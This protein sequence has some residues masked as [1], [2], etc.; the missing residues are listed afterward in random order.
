MNKLFSSAYFILVGA[1]GLSMNA[2]MSFAAHEDLGQGFFG[3]AFCSKVESY[4]PGSNHYFVCLSKTAQLTEEGVAGADLVEGVCTELRDL[5]D[6]D[7][8][9]GRCLADGMDLV[10]L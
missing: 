7:T 8:S 1:I 3:K 9:Y 10:G 5:F 4:Q 6:D 2:T